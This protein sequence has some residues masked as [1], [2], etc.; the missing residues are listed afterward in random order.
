[1]VRVLWECGKY[2]CSSKTFLVAKSHVCV[3]DKS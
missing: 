2:L 3:A 1:M